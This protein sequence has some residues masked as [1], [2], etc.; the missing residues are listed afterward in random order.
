MPGSGGSTF[1]EHNNY[2]FFRQRFRLSLDVQPTQKVGGFVQVEFRGGWGVGPDITDPR[3]DVKEAVVFKEYWWGK[4]VKELSHE[5]GEYIA[6][7]E[8]GE[9]TPVSAEELFNIR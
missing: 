2:D 8:T 1:A 7:L 3:E 4:Q 5:S 6:V 9:K